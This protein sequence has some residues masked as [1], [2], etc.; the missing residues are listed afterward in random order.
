MASALAQRHFSKPR[1]KIS[2]LKESRILKSP[3]KITGLTAILCAAYGLLVDRSDETFSVNR[4][5][6]DGFQTL[7][8]REKLTRKLQ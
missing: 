5:V 6:P 7:T 2:N 8:I 4:S 3:V 1:E